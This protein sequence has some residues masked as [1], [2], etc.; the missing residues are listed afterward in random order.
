[1]MVSS[2]LSLLEMGGQNKFGMCPVLLW[3]ER[4]AILFDAGLPGQA[5]A[6]RTAMMGE[7]VT[8]D[9][10]TAIVITHQDM[11][12][13][14]SLAALQ[15]E[16]ADRAKVMCH[17]EEKSYIQFER[18]PAKMSS[19]RILQ[20][21]AEYAQKTGVT[22]QDPVS[23]EGVRTLFS[24]QI[25][26]V[27]LGLA[28]GQELP[29]CGGIVAIHTPGHTPGHCCYYLR[30]YKTLVAGDA[31]NAHDGMLAGPNP[32]YTKDLVQARASL[33]KLAAYEIDT[34]LCYHGGAVTQP[35]GMNAT[36]AG[37]VAE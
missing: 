35:G 36:I 4:D 34:V 26:V 22:I 8:L 27:D 29:F 6:I 16:T 15:R 14:G 24:E 10:L 37:L 21:A 31:M 19:E 5:G 11:D 18:M 2:G 1:M 12:H 17:A 20:H 33:A 30:K 28:D 25:A 3:D 9:K 32:V 7:G 23:L 13:I